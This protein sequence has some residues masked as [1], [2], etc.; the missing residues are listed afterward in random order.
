MSFK[1]GNVAAATNNGIPYLWGSGD[2]TTIPSN[3]VKI[4]PSDGAIG[5]SFGEKNVAVGCGRIVVGSAYDNDNGAD[6][7]SVYIFDLN[8]TQL[9]KIKPSDGAAS[10]QFG[11]FIALGS[12]RIVVGSYLDDDNGTSSGS[13]YI[14]D[15]NGTQLAKIKP[16]DGA[17]EDQFGSSVAVGNGKI[18]VGAQYDDDNGPNSGSA[19]IFD[20]AGNQLMK[21]KPSDGK[22]QDFFGTT[23]AVGSG[24]IVVAS[25][26][27]VTVGFTGSAYIFDLEGNQLA[28][29]L[30]ADGGDD[31]FGSSVAVGSGRIVVG[32]WVDDDNFNN[33]GA[34]YIFNLNGTQLAK[35]KA[36]DGA[37]DDFFGQSVAVG[38]G[39]IVVGAWGDDDNGTNS[40]SAY[41]YNTPIVYTPYDVAELN[42]YGQ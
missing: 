37:V 14:F 33:S 6:S 9:A 41:V 10:D 19:Y 24:H 40:G 13:A 21:I 16:S 23:V 5:D 11:R 26:G 20:I 18:V 12:C 42:S 3:E 31:F 36:S 2:E 4:E 39:R 38:S 22:D 28:K 8:G 35:I 1:I 15:L 25:E 30:P 29:I 27:F 34:A 17:A 32:A 7:G